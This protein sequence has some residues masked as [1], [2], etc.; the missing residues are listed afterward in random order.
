MSLSASQTRYLPKGDISPDEYKY[1]IF[2]AINIFWN[3]TPRM[4]VG[5]EFDFGKRVN[6]SGDNRYAKRIGAMC[7]FS[8]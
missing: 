4:Q 1:G 2:S 5:A 8:F 3:M 7:M 6:F